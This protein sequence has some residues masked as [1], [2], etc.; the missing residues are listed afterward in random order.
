MITLWDAQRN[1]E[2]AVAGF[3]QCQRRRPSFLQTYVSD[4]L[5]IQSQQPRQL[6]RLLPRGVVGRGRCPHFFRQGGR[7]PHSP[8]FWTEIRAKVSPLLQLVTYRKRSVRIF[9]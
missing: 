7:V 4:M 2:K 6:P 5:Y 8:T 3:C 9:V 1:G